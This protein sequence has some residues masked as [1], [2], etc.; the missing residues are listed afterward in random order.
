MLISFPLGI[1]SAMGLL[2]CVIVLFLGLVLG[3][4]FCKFFCFDFFLFDVWCG[5]VLMVLGFRFMALGLLDSR[6]TT[7]TT[8][9]ILFS[10]KF[11]IRSCFCSGPPGPPSFYFMLPTIPVMTCTH[12]LIQLLAEMVSYE[13]F[14]MA[15]PLTMILPFSPSSSWGYRPDPLVPSF[16]VFWETSIHT[17]FHSNSSKVHS[18]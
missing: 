6:S 10:S 14:P 1:Y 12:Y 7:R 13:L 17:V 4:F 16:L 5:F 8:P 15:W 11:E 2:N 18:H 3:R 9:P